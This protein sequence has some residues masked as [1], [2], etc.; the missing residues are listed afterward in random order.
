M[1][2]DNIPADYDH[3]KEAEWQSKWE[4][5]HVH[6]FIGDGTRPK[7]IIDHTTTIPNWFHTH[8]PCS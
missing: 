1:S 8:W 6:R 2:K 7:Y 4:E 3:L 5:D